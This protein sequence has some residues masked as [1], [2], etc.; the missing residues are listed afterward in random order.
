MIDFWLTICCGMELLFKTR[1]LCW[2]L[3]SFSLSLYAHRFIENG[4]MPI[5]AQEYLMEP[6]YLPILICGSNLGEFLGAMVVL[7]VG[8]R[9]TTPILW[10]RFDSLMTLLV[11]AL[12]FYSVYHEVSAYHK[13]SRTLLLNF[14]KW[15]YLT[16]LGK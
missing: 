6:S 10:L 15:A 7:F 1:K 3:V 14:A 5:V 2:L 11:W 13:I 9:I 12:P 16:E 4:L 8:K